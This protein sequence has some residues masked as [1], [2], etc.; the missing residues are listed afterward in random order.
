V[1]L[2]TAPSHS[3]RFQ[4]IYSWK[5]FKDPFGRGCF[6]DGTTP[7]A[8]LP[9]VERGVAVCFIEWRLLGF[10]DA[11]ESEEEVAFHDALRRVCDAMT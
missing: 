1:W 4:R 11:F 7:K 8:Q 2:L 9:S 6:Y 3:G 10:G 5:S